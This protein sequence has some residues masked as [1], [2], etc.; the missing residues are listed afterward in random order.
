DYL[1]TRDDAVLT[2]MENVPY[3]GHLLPDSHA[4][5]ALFG[6]MVPLC[7]AVDHGEMDASVA[8]RQLMATV[9]SSP[10]VLPYLGLDERDE[11]FIYPQPEMLGRMVRWLATEGPAEM[12]YM[13]RRPRYA[14][15]LTGAG[16]GR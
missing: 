10:V 14:N 8:G 12:R 5:A 13:A 6:E 3:V 4:Y 11:R 7:D 2:G 16:A 9:S 15:V 1:A